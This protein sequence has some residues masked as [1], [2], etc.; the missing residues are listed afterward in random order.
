MYKF[1][2][3]CEPSL[4]CTK[5]VHSE[6]RPRFC[7]NV[8]SKS[9]INMKN[10]GKKK[11]MKTGLEYNPL[12]VNLFMKFMKRSLVAEA[13]RGLLAFIP[14]ELRSSLVLSIL[15]QLAVEESSSMVKIEA[16]KALAILGTK[17]YFS[18]ER[19]SRSLVFQGFT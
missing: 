5:T 16:V 17:A 19:I 9:G 2:K 4:I 10:E 1:C 11:K 6:T 15:N 13:C 18:Q 8:G 14:G 3:K 12:K 7:R